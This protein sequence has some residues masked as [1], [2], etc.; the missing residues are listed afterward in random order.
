MQFSIVIPVFNEAG[1]LLPLLGEIG[2]AMQDLGAYEVIC[3]DDGSDDNS[4]R[5]LREALRR[6]PYEPG[7]NANL[8]QCVHLRDVDCVDEVGSEQFVVDAITVQLVH[9]VTGQLVQYGNVA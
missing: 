3:V 6:Y 4:C 2:R 5:E 9:G 1:N 7:L 8:D